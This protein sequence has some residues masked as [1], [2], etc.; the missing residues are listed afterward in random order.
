MCV[1]HC[2]VRVRY[3]VMELICI[4]MGRY[5]EHTMDLVDRNVFNCT[6]V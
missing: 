3:A 2:T 4:V 5:C 6:P 1:L